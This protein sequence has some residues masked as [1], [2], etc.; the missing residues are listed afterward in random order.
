MPVFMFEKET[1]SWSLCELHLKLRLLQVRQRNSSVGPLVAQVCLRDEER[2]QP[3][4][5]IYLSRVQQHASLF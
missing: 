3:L 2:G 1:A 4:Q 5:P